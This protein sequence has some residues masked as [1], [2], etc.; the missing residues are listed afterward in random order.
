MRVRISTTTRAVRAQRVVGA[1]PAV[2]VRGADEIELLLQRP[3]PD[4]EDHA[5]IAHAVE[6]AVALGQL[7]WV[8]VGEHEHVGREAD[9][10][11]AR[12]EVPEG[13]ERVPVPRAT[14]R[15]LRC[16]Q[17]DVLT[18][19]EVVIAGAV[20]GLGDAQ[21]APRSPRPLPRARASWTTWSRPACRRRARIVG[22]HPC[23]YPP[24]S[25]GI[26]CPVIVRLSSLARNSARFATSSV[27]EM[28][29]SATPWSMRARCVS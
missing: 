25:T 22:A 14:A 18:A 17:R 27:D 4:A 29:R 15:D 7:E 26:D 6:G 5:A 13:G 24:A 10:A 21:R 16:R 2:V 28:S 12:R 3:D 11:R 20:G 9:P 23:M 8:V 1:W 19:G